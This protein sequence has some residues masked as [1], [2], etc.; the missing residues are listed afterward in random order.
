MRKIYGMLLDLRSGQKPA[1]AEGTNEK[2]VSFDCRVGSYAKL[3]A[4]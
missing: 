4:L 3:S 2:S 1:E